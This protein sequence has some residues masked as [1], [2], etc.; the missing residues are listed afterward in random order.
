[1]TTLRAWFS[2]QSERIGEWPTHIVLDDDDL[3]DRRNVVLEFDAVPD[4]VLDREFDAGWGA[5]ESPDLC[6][7]SDNHVWFSD[8]YDGSEGLCVVPRNPTD[9]CPIRPGG[10]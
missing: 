1:M 6:A 4:S 3:N 7:W 2:S 9:H 8:T 10:Q 5:A